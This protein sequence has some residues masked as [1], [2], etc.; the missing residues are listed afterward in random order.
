VGD[1]YIGHILQILRQQSGGGLDQN[2]LLE[3]IRQAMAAQGDNWGLERAQEMQAR[4]Q[5]REHPM[6]QY[7]QDPDRLYGQEHA[8]AMHVRNDARRAAMPQTPQIPPTPQTPQT[9][10]HNRPT[11]RLYGQEHAAAMHARNDARQ[12]ANIHRQDASGGQPIRNNPLLDAMKS[13]NVGL[14]GPAPQGTT[15]RSYESF[16]PNGMKR[17]SPF[18]TSSQPTMAQPGGSPPV[19]NP[20]TFG[21]FGNSSISRTKQR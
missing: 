12:A 18:N 8:E 3:M 20:Y 5:A 13:R 1:D 2:V 19:R 6:P 16:L 7:G 10:H 9:P 17:P 21:G 4:N 15:P 14:G 11:D